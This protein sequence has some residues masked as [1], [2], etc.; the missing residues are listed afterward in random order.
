MP[1]ANRHAP[2]VK[3]RMSRTWGAIGQTLIPAKAGTQDRVE[4]KA[5]EWVAAVRQQVLERRLRDLSWIPAF[6]GTSGWDNSR[7]NWTLVW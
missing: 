2:Q 7:P 1:Q 3:G 4:P 5:S 6:A